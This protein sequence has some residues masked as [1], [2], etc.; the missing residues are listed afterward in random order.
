[1]QSVLRVVLLALPLAMCACNE[2][3]SAPPLHGDEW[4]EPLSG[5]AVIRW[6]VTTPNGHY[7]FELNKE[8]ESAYVRTTDD[9]YRVERTLTLEEMSLLRDDLLEAQCCN[10]QGPWRDDA[11]WMVDWRIRMPGLSCD[12]T[13]PAEM[14]DSDDFAFVTCERRLAREWAFRSRMR[15]PAPGSVN[16]P[17][18]RAARASAPSPAAEEGSSD[19]Q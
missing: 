10:L 7:S 3:P 18:V 11:E 6:Q 17:A 13:M 8:G 4:P 2:P 14:F 16:W 1:M 5:D 15:V 12:I 9:E 19:D